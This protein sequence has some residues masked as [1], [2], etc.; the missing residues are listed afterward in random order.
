MGIE[1][2]ISQDG[3]LLSTHVIAKAVEMGGMLGLILG[4]LKGIVGVVGITKK[5]NPA[6]AVLK[7]C[8]AGVAFGTVWG[9]VALLAKASRD[10]TMTE[11]GIHD[12][13]YRLEHSIS[14]RSKKLDDRF[15]LGGVAGAVSVAAIPDSYL[16]EPKQ[17]E[18][19][20]IWDKIVQG[21]CVGGSLAFAASGGLLVLKNMVNKTLVMS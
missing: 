20:S 8:E 7:V 11:D 1:T 10:S 3:A 12:R 15:L 5:K 17:S 9:V 4:A 21:F 6:L 14:Q 13:V 19:L 2:L 18:K 16:T